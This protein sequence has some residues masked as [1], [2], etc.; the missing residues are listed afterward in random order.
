MAILS[1][2]SPLQ[3]ITGLL[4]GLIFRTI[5]GKTVVSAY[6]QP[7]RKKMKRKETELQ[8]MTRTRFA[9]ASKYAKS[10]MRDPVKYE[11]YKR[12]AK[13]LGVSSAYTAAITD[14]MRKGSIEKI[15]TS[16]FERKGQVVV[17]AGKKDLDLSNV[18]LRVATRDGDILTEATGKSIGNGLWSFNY[19]G[20]P[21]KLSDVNLYIEAWDS[22]GNVVEVC[23]K[24]A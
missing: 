13:K 1:P 23:R 16:K 2:T 19:R 18:K 24:A 10:I 12:K 17:K 4:G 14:F 6:S 22:V 5:D 20:T 8:K 7:S 15:D 21:L 9:D 11:Y 3:G